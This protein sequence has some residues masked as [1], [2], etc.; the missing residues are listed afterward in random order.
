V[1]WA[2]RRKTKIDLELDKA[3]SRL[4]ALEGSRLGGDWFSGMM[5]K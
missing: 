1:V 2:T 5:G 3:N 4:S